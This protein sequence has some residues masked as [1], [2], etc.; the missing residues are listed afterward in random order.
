MKICLIILVIHTTLRACPCKNRPLK[1]LWK[2]DC[3][4]VLCTSQATYAMNENELYFDRFPFLIFEEF[5]F[6][7]S[8]KT[9]QT[10]N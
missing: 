5:F 4:H 2:M 9:T 3:L 1:F 7:R 8:P 6:V 10:G